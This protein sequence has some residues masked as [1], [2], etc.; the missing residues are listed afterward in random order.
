MGDGSLP[1]LAYRDA[2]AQSEGEESVSAWIELGDVFVRDGG[3]TFG[4]YEG[5]P[6]WRR[7]DDPRIWA[8]VDAR[9][10]R[11]PGFELWRD[12]GDDRAS[13]WSFEDVGQLGRLAAIV[14]SGRVAA[15]MRLGPW[16]EERVLSEGLAGLVER[17]PR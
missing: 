12:D 6:M 17:S 5:Q 14:G 11:A 10:R 16:I 7:D 3:W 2:V 15:H 13:Y 1:G 8:T 4:L 9:P